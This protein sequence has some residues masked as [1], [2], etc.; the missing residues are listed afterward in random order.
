MFPVYLQRIFT[1][2]VSKNNAAA[3]KILD[4]HSD[5]IFIK[6]DQYLEKLYK[7]N[8]GF[9]I[10]WN[11]VYK[12]A[13]NRS[14]KNRNRLWRPV[15]IETKQRN[16]MLLKSSPLSIDGRYVDGLSMHWR[17]VAAELSFYVRW[18]VDVEVCQPFS[19]DINESF[20][21]PAAEPADRTLWQQSWKPCRQLLKTIS[22]LN[23]HNS[24]AI[25]STRTLTSILSPDL[26]CEV[27]WHRF[28]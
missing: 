7:E 11:T 16:M 13:K 18:T 19:S 26:Y 4:E 12:N 27:I 17:E 23:Q 1:R 9:P 6:T 10:F 24:R 25:V 2:S 8:K 15:R 5:V 3:R 22:S 14:V 28:L 20:W 21:R